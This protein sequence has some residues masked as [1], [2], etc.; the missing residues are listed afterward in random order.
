MLDTIRKLIFSLYEKPLL[1]N[2]FYTLAFGIF[3][4]V[5]CRF[6]VLAWRFGGDVDRLLT[7][8]A[9]F[10][11]GI[12]TVVTLLRIWAVPPRRTLDHDAASEPPHPSAELKPDAGEILAMMR[13]SSA[14]NRQI[15]QGARALGSSRTLFH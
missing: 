8:I 10:A 6:A 5:G 2:W 4:P 13:A 1:R 15:A 3:V 9:G 11:V 14:R 12:T 7:L